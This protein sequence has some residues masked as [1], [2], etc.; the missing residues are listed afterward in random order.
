MASD[1]DAPLAKSDDAN[2]LLQS[3][4]DMATRSVNVSVLPQAFSGASRLENAS[5]DAVGISIPSKHTMIA[6]KRPAIKSRLLMVVL[7]FAVLVVRRF[8]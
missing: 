4:A 3:L 8:Y 5:P 7:F 1:Q 6:Q 2:R